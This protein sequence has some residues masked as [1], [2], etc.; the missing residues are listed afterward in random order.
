MTVLTL[1]SFISP[2]KTVLTQNMQ[3]HRFNFL[4]SLSISMLK[5]VKGKLA[6]NTCCQHQNGLHPREVNKKSHF[7]RSGDPPSNKWNSFNEEMVVD[8]ASMIDGFYLYSNDVTDEKIINFKPIPSHSA[9]T[10]SW[11]KPIKSW[12]WLSSS[13]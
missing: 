4:P 1:S 10:T 12:D 2:L 11:F 13:S 7:Y 8:T 9:R 3:E 6:H 5:S